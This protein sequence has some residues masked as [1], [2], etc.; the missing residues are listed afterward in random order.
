MKNSSCSVFRSCRSWF[1][2]NA[3]IFAFLFSYSGCKTIEDK[4]KLEEEVV[5]KDIPE[6]EKTNNFY[7]KA[8]RAADVTS[9]PMDQEVI[10]VRELPP[11]N[12]KELD[13][14]TTTIGTPI[15]PPRDEKPFYEKFLKE[16]DNELIDCKLNLDSVPIRDV[17]DIMAGYLGFQYIIDPK[18][19]KGATAVLIN[20]DTQLTKKQIWQLFEQVLWLSG[21][22]C[23]PGE[24][25]IINIFP[26]ELMPQQRNATSVPGESNVEVRLIRLKYVSPKD[27]MDKVTPFMTIGSKIVEVTGQNGMLIVEAPANFPKIM[28]LIRMLDKKN[29]QDWPQVVL[30]CSSITA[31]SVKEE[32]LAILPVLG[33]PVS[34]EPG[35]GTLPDP[36]AIQIVANDRLQVLIASAANIEALDEVKK[37]VA[38]L[39]RADIGEQER[40]FVYKVINSTAQELLTAISAIFNTEGT[41]A[42]ASSSSKSQSQISTGGLGGDQDDK[43]KQQQQKQQPKTQTPPQLS[44]KKTSSSGGGSGEKSSASIF[45]VPS[46]IFADDVNNRLLIRTTPRTYAMIKAV[47]ERLDSVPAQVLLQVMIAECT[48]NDSTQFGLEFSGKVKY[49]DATAVYGTDFRDLNPGGKEQYGFRY[50]I[51]NSDDPE[52]KFAYIRALAGTGNTKVLSTPQVVAKSHCTASIKVGDKVPIL[53]STY[54]NTSSGGAAQN[55]V[56][57][58]ETGILLTITPH[59]TEGGLIVLDLDQTVSDAVQTTTSRIDS[60]TIQERKLSTS[61]AIR[62]GGTL[63]VGGLIW[64]REIIT[65][66]SLPFIAKIPMLAALTGYTDISKRRVELLIMITGTVITEQTDLDEMTRRYEK[67]VNMMK[68]DAKK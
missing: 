50:L 34:G 17:V 53:K 32:L 55:E 37:W 28:E 1:L 51:Q 2:L 60:P 40:V 33:F 5:Q 4:N 68:E 49:K 65:Q 64:D 66:S 11:D 61:L 26:Y 24:N 38:I 47:L 36:G 42:S 25:N 21:A 31:T 20:V 63:I 13:N 3:L 57:Y 56:E 45:E 43:N 10:S 7:K 46:K 48:L 12:K 27:V 14:L 8:L 67:A 59:V 22:Y 30:A 35:A 62:D 44:N 9:P 54:T 6:E 52:D 18:V 23:Y 16:G 58:Q 19:N 29:R 15:Q 41:S 39:D